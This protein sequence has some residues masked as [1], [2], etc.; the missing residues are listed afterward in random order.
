MGEKHRFLVSA[1]VF[2]PTAKTSLQVHQSHTINPLP[3]IKNDQAHKPAESSVFPLLT[4]LPSTLT[5]DHLLQPTLHVFI[6]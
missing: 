4:L 6:I 3:Y 2:K 5:S 1:V